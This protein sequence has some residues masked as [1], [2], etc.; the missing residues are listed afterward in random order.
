M[1]YR[2]PN[3]L[4]IPQIIC[5]TANDRLSC[6]PPHYTILIGVITWAC[7]LA[8]RAS[9]KFLLPYARRQIMANNRRLRNPAACKLRARSCRTL[10]TVKDS[11]CRRH[12]ARPCSQLFLWDKPRRTFP[13][14]RL[15]RTL[16]S[17]RSLGVQD[18]PPSVNQWRA[19]GAAAGAP[20][21]RRALRSF[22]ATRGPSLTTEFT[23][24][25]DPA[26]GTDF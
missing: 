7:Y 2:Y 16:M 18:R 10:R 6:F 26:P 21:P 8:G 13:R 1:S 25:S 5:C 20:S 11:L 4:V 24:P 17:R 23:V 15:K 19:S 3:W 12:S 9:T 22:P 14:V